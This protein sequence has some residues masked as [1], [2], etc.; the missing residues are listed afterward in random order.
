M[1]RNM[2]LYNKIYNFSIVC[3]TV[4]NGI[5]ADFLSEEELKDS[6]YDTYFDY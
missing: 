6:D 2:N 5:E 4:G 1:I 3:S